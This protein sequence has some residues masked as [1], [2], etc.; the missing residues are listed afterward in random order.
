MTGIDVVFQEDASVLYISME[1]VIKRYSSCTLYLRKKKRK[2]RLIIINI[3]SVS[4]AIQ[5][6][7]KKHTL[8]NK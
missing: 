5:S 4:I 1:N 3:G 7:I 2:E 6:T 8:K